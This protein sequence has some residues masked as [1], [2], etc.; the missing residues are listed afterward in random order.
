[1]NADG[2]ARVAPV[3]NLEGW[4]NFDAHSSECDADHARIRAELETEIHPAHPFYRRRLEVVAH[5]LGCDD[6][7]CTH[8]DEPGRYSVLHLTW[9]GRACGVVASRLR[10]FAA[11]SPRGSGSCEALQLSRPRL[12]G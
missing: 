2:K 9:G 12:P 10:S 5:A 4:C 11:R 7:L 8:V 1:M 3:A 6:V